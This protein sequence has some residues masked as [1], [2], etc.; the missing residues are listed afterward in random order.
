MI[1]ESFCYI[2]ERTRTSC[3]SR[4][5]MV[6]LLVLVLPMAVKQ[7][8]G[9]TPPAQAAGYSLMFSDDFTSL[10]LS[11][12]GT[13][14][15]RWYDGVWFYNNPAPLANIS[16]ANSELSLVWQ[17]SQTGDDTSVETFAQNNANYHA[18]RYGYFEARMKW[19]VVTGAWPAFWLTPIEAAFGQDV[20]NG[21]QEQGEFDIFEGQGDQPHIYTGTIHDWV[22]GKSTSNANN[23]WTLASTVDFSQY[24]TYGMLWI[25]GKVTWYFDDQPLMS[26]P[27]PTV[28]DKQTYLMILGMQEGAAWQGGNLTGVTVSSMKLTVDWVHVWQLQT[29]DIPS[30][31]PQTLTTAFNTPEAITLSGS[32]PAQ[33]P[34]T[35]AI[36]TAPSHGQITGSAPNITYIP[37]A[38]YSG[39]DS[40][41]FNANNGSSSSASATVSIT[42]SPAAAPAA[43]GASFI[44]ADAA[45]HGSWKGVYGADGSLIA[46]DSA[47]LPS[48]AS[49]TP[50]SGA[51]LYT[52]AASTTDSRALLKYL[53]SSDR[54]AST[55][56]NW[57]GFTFDI[58]LTDGQAHRVALYCLDWDNGGRSQSITITDANSGSKLDSRT[59]N[60]FQNG[61]YLIWTIAGH[62]HLQFNQLAG[63]NAVVSGLFFDTP[64]GTAPA[65]TVTVSFNA[66]VPN[67]TAVGII[68]LSTIA[69]SAAGIASVQY[70]IDGGNLTPAVSAG[71]PYLYQW[72]TTTVA[73]GS[74]V[75]KAIATD[76]RGQQASASVAVNVNNVI[77]V[78]GTA[79]TFVKI[80]SLTRGNW[81]GVY[82]HD[83]EIIANDSSVLPGYASASVLSGAAPFT[84]TITQD[85]KALQQANGTA[86][87]AS[88]FYG[89]TFT[90]DLNSTDGNTHQFAVYLL[91]WDGSA[92]AE[93]ITLRDAA[94]QTVLDSET[95][96]AFSQGEYLVWNVKGHVTVQFSLTAGAN[97]VAS[98]IFLGPAS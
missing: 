38:G 47:N 56:Y 76:N 27:T 8:V 61:Q 41:T 77:A 64:G 71:P 46:N 45:T 40:F 21:A 74:H 52:W 80:D 19:D 49:V 35:Y 93:T 92:R 63:Q 28:V 69:S 89:S 44:S 48:Y 30:A 11:P 79:A 91:D 50:G 29:A 95:A 10:N 75:V 78:S 66:P 42:V 81:K 16:V 53:S 33:L 32:D 1:A 51:A 98:G 68:A 3:A 25:P 58:N 94:T 39:A 9:A 36:V 97:A 37:N 57:P 55:Y 5:A 73:N 2:A 34:L 23:T 90:L 31:N 85:P 26:A 24:H 86:R 88:T 67:Q 43:A 83:G 17:K 59:M 70:Q 12:N 62:V 18:W 15:Y 22:N 96:S 82:G 13:G 60:G 14:N 87:T 54:I 65:P 6:C 4:A 84:W 20:Y 7:A 72:D